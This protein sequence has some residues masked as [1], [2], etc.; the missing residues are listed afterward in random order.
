[1]V[2]L[3]KLTD[4]QVALTG[5]IDDGTVIEILQYVDGY[6]RVVITYES[7][8][9]SEICHYVTNVLTAY[10][11]GD[12]DTVIDLIMERHYNRIS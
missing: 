2:C 5:E 10:M 6:A 12:V 7:V 11:R 3:I 4:P 8:T 1:M 9:L